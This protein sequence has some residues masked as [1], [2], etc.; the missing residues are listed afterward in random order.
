MSLQLTRG[1]F[2][3]SVLAKWEAEVG[4]SISPASH[5]CLV[6]SSAQTFLVWR[7]WL[8]DEPVSLSIPRQT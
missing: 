8:S 4:L 1:A 6:G 2:D 5:H 3:L 7:W